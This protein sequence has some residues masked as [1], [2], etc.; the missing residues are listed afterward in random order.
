M[1]SLAQLERQRVRI[2]RELARRQKQVR[3]LKGKIGKTRTRLA[4]LE[5][6][7][8]AALGAAESAAAKKPRRK[9]R[10]RRGRSQKDVVRE[11]LLQAKKPLSIPEILAQLKTRGY[12]W[13]SKNPKAALS[14]MLYTNQKLFKRAK[15]GRFAVAG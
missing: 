6:G 15:P 13:Q 10:R 3:Q 5:A 2:G 1:Q 4:K 8:A 12:R 11:V 14:V 7:L 9:V